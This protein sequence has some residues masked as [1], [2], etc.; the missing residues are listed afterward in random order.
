M[1]TAVIFFIS[2]FYTSIHAQQWFDPS[3]N[4]IDSKVIMESF[5]ATEDRNILKVVINQAGVI[6]LN[7]E[8][9]PNISEIAFKERVLDFIT[10]P[11]KDNN[12]AEKPEKIYFL[13]KSF[14]ENKEVLTTLKTYIQDVYIYLWDK[15]AE[16]RYSSAYI[17]LKCKK[18]N[19]IF[20]DH[21]LRLLFE[22]DAEQK[23]EQKKPKRFGVPPFKGD[24][25]DN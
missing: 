22:P 5:N 7:E 17:D 8:A 16:E 9:Q 11:N 10:N 14:N 2:L 13:L 20:K 4:K 18:R 12:K 15:N 23:E 19:K 1:K 24:V 21:P 6:E 3:C 25:I